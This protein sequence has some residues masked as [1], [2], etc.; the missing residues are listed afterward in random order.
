MTENPFAAPEG[1]APVPP[2]GWNVPPQTPPS[3][4]PPGPVPPGQWVVPP[5]QWAYAVAP[6]RPTNGLAIAAMVLGI[7]W[8]YWLGSI[9]A[10]VFGHIALHQMKQDPNQNGRG[11]A[12]AGV[13]LGWTGVGIGVVV[14]V[15]A[16]AAAASSSG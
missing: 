13:A 5:Q 16:I 15:I 10:V 12:I 11:M 9:L 1:A 4:S 14:A 7:I 2:S 3:Y 8:I 6:S